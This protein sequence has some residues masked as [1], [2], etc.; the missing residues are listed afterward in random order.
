M[1]ARLTDN[2]K[3]ISSPVQ[4]EKLLKKA[5]DTLSNLD[6]VYSKADI[7]LKRQ[8]IGSIFPE[9]F[10]LEKN[11]CRTARVNDIAALIYQINNELYNK[12]SRTLSDFSHKFGLVPGAGV[13]PARV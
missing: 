9:K 5:L 4:I 10:V 12:K 1:E 6:M 8:I 7:Q 3:G 2:S 11:I 13:E